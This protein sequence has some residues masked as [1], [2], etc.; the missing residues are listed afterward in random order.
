MKKD[1]ETTKDVPLIVL[2]SIT[3]IAHLFWFLPFTSMKQEYAVLDEIAE[4]KIGD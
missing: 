4:V 2:D 1:G 3:S